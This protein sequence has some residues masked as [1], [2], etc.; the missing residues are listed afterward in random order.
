MGSQ[1]SRGLVYICHAL[2]VLAMQAT[3]EAGGT[4][5]HR[6]LHIGILHGNR[7]AGTPHVSLAIWHVAGTGGCR[8]SD[9][10]TSVSGAGPVCIQSNVTHGP[11]VRVSQYSVVA[12]QVIVVYV[13]AGGAQVPLDPADSVA[14]DI[15][16]GVERHSVGRRGAVKGLVADLFVNILIPHGSRCV[17]QVVAIRGFRIIEAALPLA[18]GATVGIEGR[19]AESIAIATCCENYII[20]EINL[21]FFL[22]LRTI[23]HINAEISSISQARSDGS[24]NIVGG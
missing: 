7:G 4:V 8:S 24:G 23:L 11:E 14:Q 1:G 2:R 17:G 5:L 9:S 3:E 20:L 10:S 12:S 6:N 22:I 21:F 15:Q 18:I 19:T 13:A 16:T